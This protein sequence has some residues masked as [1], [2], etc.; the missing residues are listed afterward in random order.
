MRIGIANFVWHPHASTADA[1]LE[2][3]PTLTGWADAI[4]ASADHQVAVFQRFDTDAELDRRGVSYRF[5]PDTMPASPRASFSGTG[6]LLEAIAAFEPD[7]VHVNGFQYPAALRRLARAL[8]RSVIVVQDHGGIDLDRLNGARRSWMRWGLGAAS[9]LLVATPAQADAFRASG[10]VPERVPIVDVMESSTT[11]RAD[12]S[13][14]AHKP[15][16]LLCVGRLNANKDPLTVARGFAL[17]AKRF[18]ES[19]LTFIYH[20]PDLEASLRGVVER[21]AVLRSR[22][23]LRGPVAHAQ[24]EAMYAKS[25]I[26]VL[27]SHREGSG[28]AALEAMACGVV[29]V[30]SDIASFRSLTD[31]GRIGA[32]WPPGDPAALCAALEHVVATPIQSNRPDVRARFERCFSWDAIGRRAAA[33]YEGF[34]AEGPRT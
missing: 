27:G 1:L 30:L 4:H 17:F 25:D 12:P 24:L 2:R 16:A 9:A 10:L 20:A 23:T 3:F 28:Y 14:A 32:L 18:P 5:V 22:V 15:L 26:F 13:R 31:N 19:S 21:D 29:P 6:A 34:F 11:F 8:P 7:V 33:I